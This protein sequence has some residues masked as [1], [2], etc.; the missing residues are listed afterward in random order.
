TIGDRALLTAFLDALRVPRAWRRRILRDV[1]RQAGLGRDLAALAPS[2]PGSRDHSAFLAA[3]DGADPKAARAVVEDMLSLARISRVG[4]RSASD[5]AE[6][7][8]EQAGLRA[9]AS[10]PE[11]THDLLTRFLTIEGGL[12]AVM[13]EISDCVAQA[14][15][16]GVVDRDG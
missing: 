5:I 7:F 15:A 13:P 9:S 14:K 10:L 4:G 3:L 11:A 12:E 1:T 8:I 2:A 16:A 6:R